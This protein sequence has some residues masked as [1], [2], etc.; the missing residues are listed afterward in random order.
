MTSLQDFPPPPHDRDQILAKVGPQRAQI[1]HTVRKI[2]DDFEVVAR[3]ELLYSPP[4][5]IEE[6]LRIQT[7]LLSLIEEIPYRISEMKIR[8][9]GGAVK[10]LLEQVPATVVDRETRDVIFGLL[11]PSA[12]AGASQWTWRLAFEAI[13]TVPDD[14]LAWPQKELLKWMVGRHAPEPYPE[15][16]EEA[17]DNAILSFPDHVI[18]GPMKEILSDIQ[19]YFD[20]IREMTAVDLAK[21]RGRIEFFDTTDDVHLSVREREFTCEIAADLK[22][23]YSSAI[24][25]AASNLVARGIWNGAEVEPVLFPEK[26]EEFERNDQLLDTL[27]EILASIKNLLSDVPLVE[28]VASWEQ[29]RR[30]DRYA[31][32]HLYGFLGTLG[33]LM[34]EPSRRALY[35]GDYHQVQL[36]EHRLANRINELNMLHN[37]TWDVLD[38]T[39][40][41]IHGCYSRMAEKAVELA[42]VLD[43]EILKK[44]VGEAA[45]NTMLRIVSI[46]GE[47]RLDAS[48]GGHEKNEEYRTPE[49]IALRERL[50]EGLLGVTELLHDEDLRTFFELLLGAV[51]KR[52]SFAVKRRQA[53]SQDRIP[54]STEEELRAALDDDATVNGWLEAIGD[55]DPQNGPELEVFPPDDSSMARDFGDSPPPV[56]PPLAPEFEASRLPPGRSFEPR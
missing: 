27:S 7:C 39:H 56:A 46:E 9:L 15:L 13:D 53:E 31:L 54:V 44:L 17:F 18:D 5:E 22:G 32:T 1:Y 20:G 38:E 23:K 26:A 24:A 45:V 41:D 40:P 3:W 16:S 55:L 19:V 14:I 33:Q 28:L 21:L 47:K 11:G 4:A 51:R 2:L 42:A 49:S 30:V 10:R 48:Q 43:V 6:F 34:K 25:S 35:C 29:R 52:I 37:Q 36:R 12:P 50:P 8:I